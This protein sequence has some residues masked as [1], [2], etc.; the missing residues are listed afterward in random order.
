MILLKKINKEIICSMK[1]K[2][3]FRLS[4]LKLIKNELQNNLKLQ[5]VLE[6][7]TVVSSYYKKLSKSLDMYKE[8]A[9]LNNLKEELSIIKEFMPKELSRED[10]ENLVDKYKNLN[11]FGK[12]MKSVREEVSGLFDGALVS[13]IIKERMEWVMQTFML[14]I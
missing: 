3:K 1:E 7:T 8:E 13:K 12:I 11:N 10:L 14:E 4:V 5:S 6:E 2:N 9:A